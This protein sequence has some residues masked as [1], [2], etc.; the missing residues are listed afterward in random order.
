[1]PTQSTFLVFLALLIFSE[2]ED[3]E[4]D[5]ELLELELFEELDE[6]LPDDEDDELPDE[7]FLFLGY[8][9]LRGYA[10]FFL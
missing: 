6:L 10:G 7:L 3:D 5:D 9:F 8:G 1:M 4:P 2:E